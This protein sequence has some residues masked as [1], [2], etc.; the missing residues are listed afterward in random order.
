MAK[1]RQTVEDASQAR[2]SI[3]K[4]ATRPALTQQ[5]LTHVPLYATLGGT[6]AG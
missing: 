2:L 6:E 3:K 4:T 5:G 1:V